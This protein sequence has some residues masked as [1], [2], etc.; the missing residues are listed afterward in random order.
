MILPGSGQTNGAP[1]D[2]TAVTLGT[3]QILH[4]F[5]AGSG[6]PEVLKAYAFNSDLLDPVT[7]HFALYDSLAALVRQWAVVVPVKAALVAAFDDG[8]ELAAIIGNNAMVLKVYA[9]TAS[10]LAVTA[11]VD[12][13]ASTVNTTTFGSGQTDGQ[14]LALTATTLAGAQVLHTFPAG[15]GDPSIAR[16]YAFNSDE[17]EGLTLNLALY[18]NSA[19]LIRE[20]PVTVPAEGALVPAFSQKDTDAALVCNGTLVLKAYAER[21]AVLAVAAR[22]TTQA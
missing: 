19:V 13:Q 22:I 9:E 6:T 15:S 17:D 21:T 1:L 5:V 18:D 8:D 16:V 11:Q 20:W 3:A 4:T 14:P 2:I 10:L 12:D 7:L